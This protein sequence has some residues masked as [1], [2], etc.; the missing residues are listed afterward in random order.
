MREWKTAR[1]TDPSFKER[2]NA[3]QR[4]LARRKPNP[5]VVDG[6][7]RR[8]QHRGSFCVVHGNRSAS[9]YVIR[10]VDGVRIVEHRAVM[11]RH[12]GRTLQ[13]F[14]SVHHKNGQRDDNRLSNLELW[15]K[16]QPSGQRPEDL[17]AWVVENYPNM[18]KAALDQSGVN[19]SG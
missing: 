17:V 4:E 1:M 18:V 16:P 9:G 2:Y 6:C 15:T 3:R 11:E 19:Y 14:E 12:L 8:K 7:D 5:C 10:T 13:P